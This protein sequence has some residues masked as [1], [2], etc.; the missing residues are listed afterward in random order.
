[1]ALCLRGVL[2]VLPAL[3]QGLSSNVSS[4]VQ[5]VP[6]KSREQQPFGHLDQ[7]CSLLT[8]LEELLGS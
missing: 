1:M 6:P 5:K 4:K 3:V 2:I 8:V 7:E